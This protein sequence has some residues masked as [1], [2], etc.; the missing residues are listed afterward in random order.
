MS[1]N[2]SSSM[3]SL[4]LLNHS[5]TDSSAPISMFSSSVKSTRTPPSSSN[6]KVALDSSTIGR[7]TTLSCIGLICSKGFCSIAI[8]IGILKF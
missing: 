5:S 3:S 2:S 1:L 4:R 7:G 6:S 8:F